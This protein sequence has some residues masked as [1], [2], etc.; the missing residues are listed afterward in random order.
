MIELL[1]SGATEIAY[2]YDMGGNW[3]HRIIV[4]KLK[5]AEAAALYPQFLGGE[6]RCPPENCGGFPG[7]YEF[8]GNITRKQSKKRR[9]ALDCY[10]GPYNPDDID[11]QQIIANLEKHG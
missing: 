3:Q 1:A 2:L 8:L 4:E 9:A 10:G 5:P 6:R 11:E 7:Y